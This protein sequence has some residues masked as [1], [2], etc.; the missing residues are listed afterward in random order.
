M[1]ELD[2]LERV[3]VRTKAATH[4]AAAAPGEP[5][6]PAPHDLRFADGELVYHGGPVRP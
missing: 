5:P 3:I 2:R 4:A 1:T 6:R